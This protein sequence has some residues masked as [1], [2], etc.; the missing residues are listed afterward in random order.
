MRHSLRSW[1]WRV[2]V[3]QEV[4]EELQFHVEMRRREL[5]RRGMDPKVARDIVLSRIGTLGQKTNL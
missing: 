5:I 3:H 1:L 2:S 4:D